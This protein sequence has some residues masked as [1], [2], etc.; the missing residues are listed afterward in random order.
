MLWIK[1]QLR[2][3]EHNYIF[4]F[5]KFVYAIVASVTLRCAT[6][7]PPG[8]RPQVISAQT[9]GLCRASGAQ[10]YAMPVAVFLLFAAPFVGLSALLLPRSFIFVPLVLAAVLT[11]GGLLLVYRSLL[12]PLRR[13]TT[14]ARAAGDAP[15]NVQ[16][17][18]PLLREALT[19][20]QEREH[21]RQEDFARML[22]EKEE[23]FQEAVEWHEK[24]SV[25]ITGQRMVRATLDKVADKLKSLAARLPQEAV[26]EED[27]HTR[28]CRVFV[29]EALENARGE[30]EYCANYL[31]QMNV[32]L[33]ETPTAGEKAETD[34]QDFFQWSES[35]TTGVPLSTASTSCCSP[36][37]I[38]WP[39]TSARAATL[40]YC[41]KFWT[42]W[43]AMPSPISILRKFS[44]PH[45]ATLR[46]ASISASTVN[47]ARLW[48]NS[49]R[50]WTKVGPIL[51]LIYWN[52]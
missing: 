51:I 22:H 13:L 30:L 31:D 29:T 8:L 26:P 42:R 16:G 12:T 11:W 43:R 33:G 40:P 41:W 20:L 44:L 35:Y 38:N 9:P 47:F 4:I 32:F 21:H 25:A 10:G 48:L 2:V 18:C 19:A 1:S 34:E 46:P 27:A 7:P 36:T 5:T 6:A 28:A 50:L 37:S 17:A 39:A 24:Y 15:L 49:V 52:F 3:I 14:S 23:N 45:P